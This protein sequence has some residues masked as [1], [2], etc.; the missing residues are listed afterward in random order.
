LGRGINLV[1]P[2]LSCWDIELMIAKE[3]EWQV[4]IYYDHPDC[5]G[6]IY[7]AQSSY[8]YLLEDTI[9]ILEGRWK[10]IPKH[11]NPEIYVAVQVTYKG[12]RRFMKN[13]EPLLKK[14]IKS[15]TNG[16]NNE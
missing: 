15:I 3:L 14:D 11:S 5:F 13:I 4:G 6:E 16:V 1:C 7:R 8:E 9:E 2:W 12:E 10:S